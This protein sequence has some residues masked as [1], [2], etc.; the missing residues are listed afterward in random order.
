MNENENKD[1]A[2]ALDELRFHMAQI[3]QAGDSLDQKINNS[4]SAAGL[5]MALTS[6]LQ[7]SL[8]PNKTNLYWTIL[9]FAVVL[10]IV[11]VGLALIGTNPQEYKLAISANWDEL[12]ERLFGKDERDSILVI[13][14]GYVKQ[15]DHN[16]EIN[17]KKAKIFRWNLVLLSIIV[18]ALL[19]LV[20][21]SI[22]GI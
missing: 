19:S 12:D 13:L 16:D 11:T 1:V 17:K 5:I 18:L 22:L 7:I 4:L 10:Y 14:S 9:F 8:A 3:L 15:I 20:P 21:V 6:T 2:L